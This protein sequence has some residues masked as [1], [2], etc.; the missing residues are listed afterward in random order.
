ML[1]T[2]GASY[3]IICGAMGQT[4][5]A[6]RP[7][8]RPPVYA[9][10]NARIVAA[11]RD[12]VTLDRVAL[13]EGLTKMRVSQIVKGAGVRQSEGGVAVQ[14]RRR[15]LAEGATCP[16]QLTS[17][18]MRLMRAAEARAGTG[19]SVSDVVEYGLRLQAGALTGAEFEPTRDAA[20]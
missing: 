7:I 20:A 9:E 15:E 5:I 4:E 12:G 13:A 17:E 11:F 8:G 18:A 3:G 16:V 10:R 6:R 19:A 2:L 14:R 1:F